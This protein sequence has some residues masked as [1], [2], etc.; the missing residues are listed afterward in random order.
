MCWDRSRIRNTLLN[1]AGCLRLLGSSESKAMNTCANVKCEGKTVAYTE[2]VTLQGTRKTP[3]L[4]GQFVLCKELI[5]RDLAYLASCLRLLGTSVSKGSDAIVNSLQSINQLHSWF[6][7]TPPPNLEFLLNFKEMYNLLK[8]W[9]QVL[10]S[11]KNPK[12]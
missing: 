7:F 3:C 11:M 5:W 9:L 8:T 6:Y 12:N 10:T 2:H 1:L 4:S